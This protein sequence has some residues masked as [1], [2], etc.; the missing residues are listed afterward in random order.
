[1]TTGWP[2]VIAFASAVA[3][4]FGGSAQP[5]PTGTFGWPLRPRPA[6]VHPFD[7]PPEP[8][9]AG[10]RGVDLQG[11]QG[12]PVLAAG[13]GTVSFSGVIAGRGVVA[14]QHPDGRRTT[15]EPVDDRDPKGTVEARGEPIGS[16]AAGGHC[17][18]TPCLHWGLLV[19]ADAYR[20]PLTLVE[21]R[22]VRLLPLG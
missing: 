20:D 1:M 11:T 6:V 14:I 7:A 12:Q 5:A 2:G 15:Y 18:T 9:A 8:W 21:D 13:A 19:G 10:H 3:A 4:A 22:R 17:G 16:L